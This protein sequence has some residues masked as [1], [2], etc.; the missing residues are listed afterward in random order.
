MFIN[1]FSSRTLYDL[2]MEFVEPV[3]AA[4]SFGNLQPPTNEH[5]LRRAEESPTHAM[6]IISAVG[7]KFETLTPNPETWF[8]KMVE[9][10]LRRFQDSLQLG[11]SPLV[12]YVGL[13]GESEAVR[14]KQLQQ[15]LHNAID[16]L[17]PAGMRPVG[18]LPRAWFNYAVLH[19][20]YVVGIPNREVM[21]RLHISE[22]TFNRTR[23]IAL[24]GVA[25]CLIEGMQQKRNIN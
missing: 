11:Q 8:L 10:C 1:K 20:A 5:V 18:A 24:R 17:R 13:K 19:D 22:G 3:R 6:E 14:G 2:F 25:M 15:L 12:D 7:E 16:S 21:A 4:V 23:R 9:D